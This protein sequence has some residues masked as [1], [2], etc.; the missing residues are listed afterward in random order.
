MYQNNKANGNMS[1][2]TTVFASISCTRDR[3][4]GETYSNCKLW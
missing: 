4:T 3:V 2:Q 1:Q